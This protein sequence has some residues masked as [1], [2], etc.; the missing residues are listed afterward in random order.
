MVFSGN[1]PKQENGGKIIDRNE[2]REDREEDLE[3][4]DIESKILEGPI[5][6][7]REVD[8]RAIEEENTVNNDIEESQLGNPQYKL[9]R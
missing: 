3:E 6:D 4:W 8:N 7:C 5:G 1:V 9:S 2:F